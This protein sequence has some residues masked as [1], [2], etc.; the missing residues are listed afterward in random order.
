LGGLFN[1]FLDEIRESA[2]V[3]FHQGLTSAL[4]ISAILIALAALFAAY[5][6]ARGDD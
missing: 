5:A 6:A 4:V 2:Y 1:R 3:A